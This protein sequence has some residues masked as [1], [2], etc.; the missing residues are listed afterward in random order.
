[1]SKISTLLQYLPGGGAPNSDHA[2]MK[3]GGGQLELAD[4]LAPKTNQICGGCP[5]AR[6]KKHLHF[7]KLEELGTQCHSM[8]AH[9]RLVEMLSATKGHYKLCIDSPKDIS[10]IARMTI[11]CTAFA[12]IARFQQSQSSNVSLTHSM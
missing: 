7:R 10:L 8:H 6:P 3:M 9:L 5:V 2:K 1:M 4:T 11:D 12:D